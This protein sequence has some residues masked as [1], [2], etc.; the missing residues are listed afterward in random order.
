M[1]CSQTIVIKELKNKAYSFYIQVKYYGPQYFFF[2]EVFFFTFFSWFC[3]WIFHYF[4]FK[5]EKLFW[6]AYFEM[7]IT[8]PGII[9]ILLDFVKNK[10]FF[11]EKKLKMNGP[12]LIL[13]VKQVFFFFSLFAPFILCSLP[14]GLGFDCDHFSICNSHLILKLSLKLFFLFWERKTKLLKNNKLKRK[15]KRVNNWPKSS[16]KILSFSVTYFVWKSKLSWIIFFFN[17]ILCF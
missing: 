9:I 5:L 11:L 3:S 17:L 6:L 7:T 13:F 4:A 16:N 12:N 2:F 10:V 15:R 8:C 14:P 1:F